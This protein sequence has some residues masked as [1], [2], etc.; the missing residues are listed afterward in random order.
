[1]EKNS[2]FQVQMTFMKF[3]VATGKKM[4]FDI[5]KTMVPSVLY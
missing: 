4:F 2:H 3:E 1:M 5:S